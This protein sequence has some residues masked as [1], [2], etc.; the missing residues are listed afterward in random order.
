MNAEVRNWFLNSSSSSAET[1][2]KSCWLRSD[3]TASWYDASMADKP[4]MAGEFFDSRGFSSG[5]GLDVNK[6]FN[7]G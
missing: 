2:G 5:T 6:L 3:L 4:S 1:P 7:V